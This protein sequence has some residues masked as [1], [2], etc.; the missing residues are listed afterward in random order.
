M[1]SK[2]DAHETL[3]LFFNRYS[4]PPKMVMDGSMEQTIGPFKKK[5][6][7]VDCHIKQTEPY[8]PWKLQ[9]E[10]TIRELKKGL[11]EIWFGK[12]LLFIGHMLMRY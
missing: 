11:V 4:V 7:E 10:G 3:S 8:S 9:D 5:W 2:G 6:Q 12:V 1:K